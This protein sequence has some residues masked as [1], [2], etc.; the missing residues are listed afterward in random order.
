M[1]PS[2]IN[3]DSFTA[4]VEAVI[5]AV[6]SSVAPVEAAPIETPAVEAPKED[7]PVEASND[8]SNGA[9]APIID[10]PVATPEPGRWT[11]V[12]GPLGI[13]SASLKGKVAL[14]TGAGLLG[15]HP[16]H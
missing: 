7:A 3:G 8:H 11:K 15:P 1:S 5:E 14:V 10:G 12:P 16:F 13:E 2:A 4:P 6:V 9:V